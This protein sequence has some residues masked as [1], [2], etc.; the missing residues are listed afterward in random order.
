MT[1][2]TNDPRTLKALDIEATAGQ[3]ARCRTRDGRKFYAVPSQHDA[4]VRY[5]VDLRTCTCPDFQRRGGPC[6][7][8]L[9]VQLHVARVRASKPH[10]PIVPAARSAATRGQD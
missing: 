5:L 10:P 9:A 8:I 1:I 6:K 2:D 7:H 3:W 4:N